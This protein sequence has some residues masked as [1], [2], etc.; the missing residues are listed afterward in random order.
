MCIEGRFNLLYKG[1]VVKT[2]LL[3]NTSKE[4]SNLKDSL[5]YNCESGLYKYIHVYGL[6]ALSLRR[7]QHTVSKGLEAL[8]LSPASAL[9]TL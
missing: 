8:V 4:I 5:H 6:F 2:Y 1:T 7:P 3:T 9:Y